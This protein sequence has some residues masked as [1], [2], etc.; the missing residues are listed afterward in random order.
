MF[1][2]LAERLAHSIDGAPDDDNFKAETPDIID[3][4][5]VFPMEAATPPDFG[6]DV[7]SPSSGT[8]VSCAPSERMVEAFFA[9]EVGAKTATVPRPDEPR[10]GG[11][12]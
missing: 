4:D 7:P 6:P 11:L 9:V 12:P 5:A 3:D 8:M 1:G 2:R 10:S